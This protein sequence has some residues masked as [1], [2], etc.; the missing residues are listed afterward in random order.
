MGEK[1]YPY[2][3]TCDIGHYEPPREVPAE[4]EVEAERQPSLHIQL[5]KIFM[6]FLQP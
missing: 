3:G 6:R 2:D 5:G 4:A 1:V